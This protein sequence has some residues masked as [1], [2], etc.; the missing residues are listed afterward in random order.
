ML[1]KTPGV[2]GTCL[3]NLKKEKKKQTVVV[4]CVWSHLSCVATTQVMRRPPRRRR[5][6]E[7]SGDEEE[8]L[9]KSEQ[10]CAELRQIQWHSN[11]STKTLQC[12]LDALHGK[13]GK[14]VSDGVELPRQVTLADRKMQTMVK[15]IHVRLI[16]VWFTFV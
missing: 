7:T 10:V 1:L 12:V 16:I 11:C 4:V 6:V 5:R 2:E 3:K 14:L 8:T 9:T 15:N 13:L